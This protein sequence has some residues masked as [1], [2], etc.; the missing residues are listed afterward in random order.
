MHYLAIF[1]GN[2]ELVPLKELAK[3]SRYSQQYLS[4]RTRQGKL[5]AVKIGRV[6]YSTKSALEIYCRDK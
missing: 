4:L 3:F 2:D 6:W 1:G 5:D